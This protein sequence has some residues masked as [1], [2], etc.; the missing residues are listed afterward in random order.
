[1]QEFHSSQ[2][3]QEIYGKV[4]Q[5]H[6]R[7]FLN[8]FFD[9]AATFIVKFY[10]VFGFFILVNLLFQV[11]SLVR[12]VF[13]ISLLI[14]VI[15][16]VYY[17]VV[18]N[19]KEILRPSSTQIALTAKRIG[20]GDKNIQDS[21][22]NY[23]QIYSQKDR[24]YSSVLTKLALNQLYSRISKFT[25]Q[26]YIPKKYSIS[27]VRW[28][29]VGILIIFILYIVFPL[30]M[31]RV[32]KSILIPWKNFQDPLPVKLYNRSGNIDVL[33]ND[34][35]FL[36]G[37][38]EGVEPDKI[39]LIIEQ[40][41]SPEREKK[42]F[43]TN[44]I[45]LSLDPSGTF[46][47]NIESV[48]NS[49]KYYFTAE[50]DQPRFRNRKAFSGSAMVDVEERPII[51]NLQVKIVPPKYTGLPAKLLPPNEGD[52]TAL[53][54]SKVH[55]NIEADKQL[56]AA[57]VIF[58]DS[59][60]LSLQTLGHTAQ[61]NFMIK[62]NDGY[63]LHILDTDKIFNFNPINYYIYVLS[64][65]YPY[66]EIKQPGGDIDL[67]NEL[68]VPL[69][70]EMRDDFGF[71]ELWL[72][73]ILYRYGSDQDS[74]NFKVKLP[75][76]IIKKGRA[77]SDKSWNL[78]PFYMVP[79]DY[80]RYYVEVF[81]ND[82]IT[83]PKSFK[84]G[85]YTIR[86]PSLHEIFAKTEHTQDQQIE[87]IKD[88]GRE[89]EQL[90]KR[91]E[92]IN[93]ELKKQKKLNWEQEQELKIDIAKQKELSD[94]LS[95]VRENIEDMI[96]K[97]D[98]NKVL[99]PETLEKYF[100]LQKMFQEIDS[101]E[102]KM[103]MERLNDALQKADMRQIQSAINRMQ[104]SVEQFEKQIERL[105]ALF[106]QVQLEQ[107]FDELIK[108]S[109]KIL[110]D[111]KQINN[112]LREKDVDSEDFQRM[113]KIEENI[114]NDL[115]Y[116]SQRI[117]DT[118]DEY[119]KLTEQNFEMLNEVSSYLM[120][121]QLNEKVNHTLEHLNNQ[122]TQK[123]LN[124][125][126]EV[127]SDME[128]IQNMLQNAKMKMTMQQ[129]QNIAGQM[130][131]SMQDLLNASFEQ[132][133]LADKSEDLSSAS[134]QI[135]SLARKQSRLLMDTKHLISQII[136]ISNQ[137]FLISPQLNHHM[138]SASSSIDKSIESYE[139]RNPRQAAA[140]QKKAMASFNQ[141]IL[142][143]QSSME[144]MAQAS[145]AS[146]FEEFMQQLQQLA[147]QQG[148][149]NQEGLSLFQQNQQGRLQL[150]QEDLA[151]LAAQQDIIRRSLENLSKQMGSRR[152]VLGRLD[153]LGSEMEEI[154]EELEANKFT[155]KLIER[156][157]Q[158]LSR[159]LDAQKSM[160]EK[161]Y[162]QKRKAER[163]TVKLTKSPPELRDEMLRREDFLRKKL[164]EA[165]EEGYALE[166]KELIKKYFESLSG[167]SNIY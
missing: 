134:S 114:G 100:E 96:Q 141:A 1:M 98:Q 140:Y 11:S 65:D 85:V 105:Y 26:D 27:F 16:F 147:N 31:G 68:I 39:N 23:I 84:T 43:K 130:Q 151:R 149:L 3:Y 167:Q 69:F 132:E 103:A 30:N 113:Q 6:R 59:T 45:A 73:G 36:Y 136:D 47:Y 72:K 142:S 139:N 138:S 76:E 35:V 160:R 57:E 67:Q 10:L 9:A 104:F 17:K 152:D 54:G 126:Q 8:N 108:I 111:Q 128:M 12:S 40:N 37:N 56:S 34:P 75:F 62:K 79:D 144:Q 22:I 117:K 52:I 92:E 88:I 14:W 2:N 42:T 20:Q 83:G 66:A 162:S 164:M 158:I 4:F 131:K 44:E 77:L 107:M 15:L 50:I 116:L 48:R 41:F 118:N 29:F 106:Q 163:E 133:S 78:I 99:S 64:D 87:D 28:L 46:Q 155:R 156:Q 123:A 80:I 120:A 146:G 101:P 51:R 109:E 143:L 38:Y 81:D 53:R 70:I 122:Q 115:E 25:F 21:I 153:N 5:S 102:L 91:L 33:K 63:Y 19:L 93:R 97:M 124:M 165:L 121:Q 125:G 150:S 49:F 74:T 145:S 95:K 86:L 161:E 18:P 157:R 7:Y 166:Y 135:S 127:Q 94:R 71:S 129:K 58:S 148:Q 60:R 32:L 159:M 61:G 24:R 82:I 119:R 55:I 110:Q 154:V 89:A 13:L 112:K 90:R 137:T